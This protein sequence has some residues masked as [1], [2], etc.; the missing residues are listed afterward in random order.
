MSVNLT[1]VSSTLSALLSSKSISINS[2]MGFGALSASPMSGSFVINSPMI[3]IGMAGTQSVTSV[4]TLVSNIASTAAQ[5]TSTTS[6]NSVINSSTPTLQNVSSNGIVNSPAS[7]TVTNLS[8]TNS[9]L[10]VNT[11]AVGYN[12]AATGNTSVDSVDSVIYSST[13]GLQNVVSVAIA[14]PI[15]SDVITGITYANATTSI[16]NII[17]SISAIANSMTGITSLNSIISS[18]LLNQLG[19]SAILSIPNK[20]TVVYSA[21]PQSYT[22]GTTLGIYSTSEND[23]ASG[24]L[25]HV[26]NSSVTDLTPSPAINISGVSN[27]T[28][29]GYLTPSMSISMI[30][31]TTNT[32]ITPYALFATTPT[33]K[34]S[35]A[36]RTRNYTALN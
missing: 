36:A 14:N 27:T 16:S 6:T 35:I 10:S 2:D 5:N 31:V 7:N 23:A 12:S 21:I 24:V 3:T 17:P 13:S 4:K 30:E 18:R 25:G 26:T 29:I 22:I 11:I 34:Y 15:T 33:G 1:S 32:S 19:N 8:Y 28:N 9:T 20:L